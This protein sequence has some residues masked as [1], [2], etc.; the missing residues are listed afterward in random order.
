M[1]DLSKRIHDAKK[2][3]DLKD[4]KHLIDYMFFPTDGNM[5]KPG[6]NR[7]AVSSMVMG[8]DR[9]DA[10]YKLIHIVNDLYSDEPIIKRFLKFLNK[11]R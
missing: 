3:Q 4:A 6:K 2:D 5:D 8:L 9:K 10:T 11:N 1:K 7:E